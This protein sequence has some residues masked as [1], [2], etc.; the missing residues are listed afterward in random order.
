MKAFKTFAICSLFCL[1][2]GCNTPPTEVEAWRNKIGEDPPPINT[3]AIKFA[4][5][6]LDFG[7]YLVQTGSNFVEMP[8]YNISMIDTVSIDS[9]TFKNGNRYFKFAVDGGDFPVPLLPGQR[10][11]TEKKIQI[12]F[13]PQT[14]GE[15]F[16]TL[17]VNG[18]TSNYVALHGWSDSYVK[19]ASNTIDNIDFGDITVG[20]SIELP[21][22]IT[23]T[24]SEDLK[25][26]IENLPPDETAFSIRDFG[27]YIIAPGAF[28]TVSIRFTP[29]EVKNYSED[30]RLYLR[31][32]TGKLQSTFTV[33]GKG[34]P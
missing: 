16:D 10:T 21:T 5:K 18:D 15:F 34:T 11:T 31:G 6:H 30:I 2:N 22:K 29:K 4:S 17:Y 1:W 24:G 28:K 3:S 25:L 14:A 23:N 12:E 27:E 33:T 13:Y 7:Y 20:N 8:I 19:P 9:L 26:T 32:A